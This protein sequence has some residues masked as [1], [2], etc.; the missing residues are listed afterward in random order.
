L[1]DH[2]ISLGT[3]EK[4][5]LFLDVVDGKVKELKCDNE[6]IENEIK[7]YIKLEKNADRIG[8]FAIGTNVGLTRLIGNLLQDEKFPGIHVAVG[9]TYPNDTGADWDCDPHMDMIIQKTTIEV[10]GKTIMKD[11]KFLI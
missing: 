7:T 9:H 1:G 2:L 11:G 4:N 5:P 3:I 8:E 10:D 6:K